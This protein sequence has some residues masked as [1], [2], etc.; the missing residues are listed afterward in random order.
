MSPPPRQ[1]FCVAGSAV[2]RIV[3]SASILVKILPVKAAVPL[4]STRAILAEW[5]LPVAVPC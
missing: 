5:L 4:S 1:V 2:N 3:Y